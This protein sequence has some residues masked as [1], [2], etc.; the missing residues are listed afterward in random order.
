MVVAYDQL[1]STLQLDPTRQLIGAQCS[2]ALVLARL[3]L[4]ENMPAC[5]S[6]PD[7]SSKLV[8]SRS[9]TSRSTPSGTSPRQAAA[10][11]SQYLVAWV[12]TRTV[13]ESAARR[14][15][16][17]VSPVG[18]NQETV[19]RALHAIRSTESAQS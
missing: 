10:W 15:L 8:A 16:D 4:L 1:I 19:D 9:W 5:T 17:Y 12:M 11:H 18:E 7:P 6:R 13:G 14:V 2:G 3:G